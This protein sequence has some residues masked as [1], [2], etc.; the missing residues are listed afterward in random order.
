MCNAVHQLVGCATVQ[1]RFCNHVW[2]VQAE[3][4]PSFLFGQ[5]CEPQLYGDG[6]QLHQQT[7]ETGLEL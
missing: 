2:I 3:F 4:D 1:S 7:I 5:C 6:L